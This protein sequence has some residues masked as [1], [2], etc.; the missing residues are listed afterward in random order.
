MSAYS[1]K[2]EVIDQREGY[3]ILCLPDDPTDGLQ[4]PNAASSS[5]R[6][7]RQRQGWRFILWE[8]SN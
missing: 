6:G 8:V 4:D 5:A 3:T 1:F 2:T 7:N